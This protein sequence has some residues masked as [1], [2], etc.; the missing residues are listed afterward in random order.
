MAVVTQGISPTRSYSPFEGLSERRRLQ[1]AVPRGL[2]RFHSSEA[3]DAKPVNDSIDLTFTCSLPSGFAYMVSALAFEIAVD[4]ASDWD[5]VA[6]FRIFN[7]LPN[8][9]PGNTQVSS[10]E[11]AS[12]PTTVAGDPQRVLTFGGGTLRNW[13]PNP[14]VKSTG[15]A[16]HSGILQYHNSAAAV[17]AAGTI[18][19]NL[20]FYQYEL[21]Q[22]IR[23]PL[24]FPLPVS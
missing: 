21:N 16:G 15:A 19:F 2:I 13:Y 7:G 6:R 3:L 23:Y 10:F 17:G 14:V 8:V 11:M 24:N 20:S 1:T 12:N 4:T 5:A 22:A 18:S 9:A